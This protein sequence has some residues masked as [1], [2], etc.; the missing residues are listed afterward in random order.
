MYVCGFL[1]GEGVKSYYL[2]NN[3]DFIHLS[4]LGTDIVL[5]N[6]PMTSVK[7]VGSKKARIFLFSKTG[8]V[9]KI[10]DFLSGFKSVLM[11][12]LLGHLEN[13]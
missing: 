3:F 7:E 4:L 6:Y 8:S 10:N 1:F 5:L 12:S 13:K 2:L 9:L 11:I